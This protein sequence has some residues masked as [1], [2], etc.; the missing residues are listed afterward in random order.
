MTKFCKY[1]L[2][3]SK[4]SDKEHLDLFDHRKKLCKYGMKC[5]DSDQLEHLDLFDH[6]KRRCKYGLKCKK[7]ERPEHCSNFDH[8]EKFLLAE[9]VDQKIVCKFSTVFDIP[10]GIEPEQ[11]RQK[12]M[13]QFD[14]YT[15]QFKFLN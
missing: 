15:K 7:I 9:P 3:C 6:S 10:D 2:T 1:G 13:T 12:V 5:R 14:H 11:F 8:P 4:I